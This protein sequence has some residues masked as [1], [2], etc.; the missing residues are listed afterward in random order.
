MKSLF[1]RNGKFLIP[2]ACLLFLLTTSCDDD[3]GT[4]CFD[5]KT[6]ESVD[7]YID[8]NFELTIDRRDDVCIFLGE[9]CFD[10]F[11]EGVNSGNFLEGTTCLGADSFG[12]TI[13][14]D[15]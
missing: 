15:D 9:G 14:I 8:G 10:W 12:S 11:V 5:N 4:Q 3:Y 13:V 7:V 1:F 6:R 2:F